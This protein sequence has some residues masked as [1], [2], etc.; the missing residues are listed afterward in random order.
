M[1]YVFIINNGAVSWRSTRTPLV[2]LSATESEV[3]AL[4][5]ATQEAVYLRKLANDLGFTQTCKRPGFHSNF[6]HY[7][8]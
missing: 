7:P 1:G 4:F 5:A 8:L 6:T 2:K 3:V